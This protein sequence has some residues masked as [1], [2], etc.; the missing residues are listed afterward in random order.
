[1]RTDTFRYRT[2]RKDSREIPFFSHPM[3][4]F[5]RTLGTL[6]GLLLFSVALWMIYREI[7]KMGL[8]QILSDLHS[9][10]RSSIVVAAI[11]TPLSYGLLTG[12]ELLGFRYIERKLSSWKIIF[13]AFIGYSFSNNISM[14][15]SVAVRYR[16]YSNWGISKIELTQLVAF[17]MLGTWL[18]FMMVG[19]L[20][21]LIEPAPIAGAVIVGLKF[22]RLLGAAMLILVAAYFVAGSIRKKPF[23]IRGLVLKLPSHRLISAQILLGTVDWALTG[24]V[25]YTLLPSTPSL[26]YFSFLSIFIVAQMIQIMSH[27]PGGLG[28]FESSMLLFLKP[29]LPASHILSA[30]LVYRVVYLIA[31]LIVGTLCLGVFEAHLRIT[32]GHKLPPSD[33]EPG[34]VTRD[35]A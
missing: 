34:A 15:P 4:K 35:A 29:M 31:P 32:G 21:L 33:V 16:M 20:V 18:G 22:K 13:A 23:K 7:N 6:L 17:H 14:T 12:Y 1:M 28:V 30:L 3:S 8:N 25:L 11:L 10:P 5:T 24:V 27:V 19:G 9:M 26:T 2:R